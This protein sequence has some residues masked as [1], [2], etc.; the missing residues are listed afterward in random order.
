[1][2]DDFLE[3]KN[4][5]CCSVCALWAR[6]WHAGTRILPCPFRHC[7]KVT[8]FP[9]PS[10]SCLR[11]TDG[12]CRCLEA[13]GTLYSLVAAAFTHARVQ[14]HPVWSRRVDHD[15]FQLQYRT[16]WQAIPPSIIAD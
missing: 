9:T 7:L 15:S 14:R 2:I 10:G 12:T 16:T 8:L 4:A 11:G 5:P 6:S 1:M 13:F 3:E